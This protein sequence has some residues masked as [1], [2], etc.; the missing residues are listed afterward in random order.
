MKSKIQN[1]KSKRRILWTVLSV[2]LFAG[3]VQADD[4][5]LKNNAV[6][7]TDM[8]PAADKI[9]DVLKGAKVQQLDRQGNWIK[10]SVNGKTGWVAASSISNRPQKA[11]SGL[12]GG[13]SLAQ[14]S[15]A[16]AA[17]GLE[18]M[19][20]QFASNQRLSTAGLS[21]MEQI[22]KSVTPKMLNGF[23]ADGHLGHS[24]K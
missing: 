20:A 2:G 22:K 6:V 5:W 24:G 19:A 12:L 21:K 14:S 11:D 9:A 13:N 3:A 23:M 15:S 1:P 7:R 18:P 16:A 4:V 17:K 8:S 10:I